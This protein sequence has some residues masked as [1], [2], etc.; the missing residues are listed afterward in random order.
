[1]TAVR[2]GWALH[3]CVSA[4]HMRRQIT[5]G[6]QA[7]FSIHCTGWKKPSYI[8]Q[9]YRKECIRNSDFVLNFSLLTRQDLSSL[10]SLLNSVPATVVFSIWPIFISRISLFVSVQIYQ[11]FVIHWHAKSFQFSAYRIYTKLIYT[12]S[13]KHI[14]SREKPS[15]F[16]CNSLGIQN[17]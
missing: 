17:Q 6:L 13:R 14:K 12:L 15:L 9:V 16:Y 11:D 5:H 7:V 2:S 8:C 10:N 3:L 1:M 4:L